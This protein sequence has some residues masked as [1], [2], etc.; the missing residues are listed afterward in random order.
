M[1]K[2]LHLNLRKEYFIAI[3]EGR[4][5][6]EFRSANEYWRKRLVGANYDEV[7]FKLGYPKS[8]DNDRI[9]KKKYIGYEMRDI[10]HKH[11]GNEDPS[12]NQIT[13]YAIKTTGDEV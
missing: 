11:F 10:R 7:H 2:I 13:V 8:D 12:S 6:F 1:K 5:D 3:K 9:I 4:K